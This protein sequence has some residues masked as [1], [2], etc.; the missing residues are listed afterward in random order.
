MTKEETENADAFWF[1]GYGS[2][3]WSPPPYYD[4][5]IPCFIR[6]YVRRFWMKSEDHRG[7]PEKPGRVLTLIPKDEWKQFSDWAHT[8][9]EETCWGM[10][11]RIPAVHAKYVREYLDEREINGYTPHFMPVYTHITNEKPTVDQCLVYVGTSRSPQFCPSE[12]VDKLISV[13]LS[14]RGKSGPNIDYLLKLAESLTHLSPEM[15]DT[16]VITLYNRACQILKCQ[17]QK[18]QLDSENRAEIDKPLEQQ[19]VEQS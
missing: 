15:K 18:E 6:G 2:L 10:A 9:D 4:K 12:S 3:I 5:S 19:S 8:P 16:H 1:F 7:T 13:M 14:S 17:E 11:Y